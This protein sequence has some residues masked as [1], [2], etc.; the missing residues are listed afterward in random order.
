M[1]TLFAWPQTH[2]TCMECLRPCHS[3]EERCSQPI[4]VNWL[5]ISLRDGRH[6]V[7]DICQAGWICIQTHRCW[8][9]GT[10]GIY[11]LRSV[12]LQTEAFGIQLAS[13]SWSLILAC[14]WNA[15]LRFFYT[16]LNEHTWHQVQCSL[17]SKLGT[18]C[19]KVLKNTWVLWVCG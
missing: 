6:S 14:T 17:C 9:P 10:R 12:F 13:T 5:I 2:W 16:I 18:I 4:W 19:D 15:K 7:R 1:A 8:H 3:A 11:P